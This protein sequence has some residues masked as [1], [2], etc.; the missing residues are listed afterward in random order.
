MFIT[1]KHLSRRH[2]LRTAGAGI[3]LPLLDAMV[4]AATALAQTAAAAK[5][6]CR[7]CKLPGHFA[8]DCMATEEDLPELVASVKSLD[9]AEKDGAAK[10]VAKPNGSGGTKAKASKKKSNGAKSAS[11]ADADDPDYRRGPPQTNLSQKP[12]VTTAVGKVNNGK[13]NGGKG[14]AKKPHGNGV[15]VFA[16]DAGGG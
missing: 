15:V 4:P 1:K 16:K 6:V 3:A 7:R 9:V 2:V 12:V 10:T 13:T 8:R 5:G 11:N 14:R